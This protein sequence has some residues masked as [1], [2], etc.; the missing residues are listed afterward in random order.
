MA[1][2][3]PDPPV[4]LAPPW[5]APYLSI[6]VVPPQPWQ[7]SVA[8]YV[9]PAPYIYLGAPKVLPLQA[10]TVFASPVLRGPDAREYS[11]APNYE[12]VPQPMAPAFAPPDPLYSYQG[13]ALQ[14]VAAYVREPRAAYLS[15]TFAIVQP[16]ASV[17]PNALPRAHDRAGASPAIAAPGLALFTPADPAYAFLSPPP[18]PAAYVRDARPVLSIS[19]FAISQPVTSVS[20]SVVPRAHD[21]AIAPPVVVAPALALF[22]PPEPAY[23]F[24][25]PILQPIAAFARDAR[26]TPQPSVQAIPA[27]PVAAVPPA[28]LARAD[29]TAAAPA[30]L[31]PTFAPPA[32]A[33]AVPPAPALPAARDIA[34]P[35]TQ[36]AQPIAALLATASPIYIFRGPILQPAGAYA[37]EPWLMPRTFLTKGAA[38]FGDTGPAGSA[39]LAAYQR[40]P[41]PSARPSS[42][43]SSRPSSPNSRRR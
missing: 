11:R 32:P 40:P 29:Q 10:T 24:T 43:S 38:L 37:R 2:Y 23:A 36:P 1:V 16:V 31:L 7:Q 19:T 27:T 39:R 35:V 42:A 14:L 12:A 25:G 8:A 30:R 18:Q 15:P 5:L 28:P 13:V 34:R 4:R 33:S 21:R 3:R 22:A 41:S 26:A 17:A 20:P 6:S 9:R